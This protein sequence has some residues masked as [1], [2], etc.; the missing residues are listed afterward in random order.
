MKTVTR[1]L[2]LFLLLLGVHFIPTSAHAEVPSLINFRGRL[3]DSLG[4]PIN[5][6][7]TA[8]VKLFDAETGGQ[9]IYEETIGDI[10]LQQ[11]NYSFQFGNSGIPALPTVL[12]SHADAWLEVQV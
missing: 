12:Q 1:S 11:G 8:Q 5:G 3:V 6:S 7:A 10:Q 2:L 9:L 4:A